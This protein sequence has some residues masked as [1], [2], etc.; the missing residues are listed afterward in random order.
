MRVRKSA[1]ALASALLGAGLLTVAAPAPAALYTPD[2]LSPITINDAAAASPY[3]AAFTRWGMA[4]AITD[5]NVTLFNVNHTF[6]DDLD[7]AIEAPNHD[8]VMLMSDACGDANLVGANITFDQDAANP[9]TDG[10]TCTGGTFRPTSFDGATDTYNAPWPTSLGTSLDTFTG[11]NPNGAWRLWVRDDATGDVGTITGGF[12][13]TITTAPAAIELPLGDT[14]G[15]VASP[16]PQTIT[17]SGIVGKVTDVNVSFSG[18]SHTFPDDLD[19]LLV[20]PQGQ[21]VMLMSDA[22]GDEDIPNFEYIFDDEAG[23]PQSDA[24]TCFPISVKPVDYEPGENLPGPAPAGPYG[25]SLSVFDLVN[26]NGTWQLFINDDASADSG[27]LVNPPTVDLTVDP[28]PQTTITSHPLKRT[29]NRRA[30]FRFT[31][32]ESTATFQCK[33]NLAVWKP[34]TSPKVYT[35]LKFRLHT[36]QVRAVDSLGTKDPTPAKWVWRV[37]R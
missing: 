19:V 35:D 18:L 37:V 21:K 24:G 25:T 8:A 3:P 36:F 28:P 34:C 20:G 22:C 33:L 30:T 2:S 29:T 4:G 14:G 15:G 1:V 32:N 16:Y 23:G 27:Y 31:S 26:P 17:K 9:L 13:V 5:V 7:I 12:R 10:N 6:P 11:D